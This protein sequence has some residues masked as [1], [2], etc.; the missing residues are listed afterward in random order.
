MPK[1]RYDEEKD[2]TR[3][4]AV[5]EEYCE[6]MADTYGW[7]LKQAEL[8]ATDVLPVDC[9]FDGYCEFPPSRMDLTQGDY[10]KKE[11]KEDA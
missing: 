4:A 11:E 6:D 7:T 2:E 10:F 3:H 9:V 5:S 1:P 8:V